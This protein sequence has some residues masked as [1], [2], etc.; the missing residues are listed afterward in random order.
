GWRSMSSRDAAMAENV[1]WILQRE[2]PSGRIALF[3][4]NG[5]VM[6]ARLE[7]GVWSAF[8]RPPNAMGRYLK[9]VLGDD[10]VIIGTVGTSS[11]A[12][13]SDPPIAASIDAEF[14]KIGF[15]HFILDL[16]ASGGEPAA[17]WLAERQT[18]G[19]NMTTHMALTPVSAFD[20]LLFLGTLTPA[21]IEPAVTAN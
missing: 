3:A 1:I 7:G 13:A 16:R 14:A 8:E 5:H 9:P 6:N 21:R 15:S 17:A 11:L 18:L 2:G 20:A 10:L 4:H 19:T 12:E